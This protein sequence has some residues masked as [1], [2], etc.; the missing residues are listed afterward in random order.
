M[1]FLVCLFPGRILFLIATL[2]VPLRFR[3]LAASSCL[4]GCPLSLF[5]MS[6]TPAPPPKAAQIPSYCLFCGPS[7]YKS[8][9]HHLPQGPKNRTAHLSISLQ[10]ALLF[11]N[12]YSKSLPMSVNPDRASFSM[13]GSSLPA[14][15]GTTEDTYSLLSKCS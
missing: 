7:S 1:V 4:W 3:T 5:P 9:L 14:S 13:L 12:Y 15:R 8:S 2:P 11:C 6:L 10:P